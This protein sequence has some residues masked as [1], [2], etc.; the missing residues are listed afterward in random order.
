MNIA[1]LLRKKWLLAVIAAAVVGSAAYA[2]AATL[3]VGSSSLGA[4]NVGVSACAHE[5]DATYANTYDSALTSN[6]VGQ[7]VVGQVNLS[8]PADTSCA[9]NDKVEVVLT[10]SDNNAL[11]NFIYTIGATD[12]ASGNVSS[13]TLSVT[14]TG[15]V[16]GTTS[17]A[18][19]ITHDSGAGQ[20][21]AFTSA[22]GASGIPAANVTGIAVSAVGSAV[23]TTNG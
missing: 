8:F 6:G 14:N 9:P 18:G 2:F 16:S 5:I 17:T 19:E 11:A 7:F 21:P 13:T 20:G 22:S 1:S 4:G 15:T 3:S 12:G 23:T 10:D